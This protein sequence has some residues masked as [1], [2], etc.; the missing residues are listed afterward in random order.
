MELTDLAPDPI[1]QF[2]I[3]YDEIATAGLAEPT[4]MALTTTPAEAHSQPISRHVLL[5][6]VDDR[7]FAWV[8]NHNSRKGRHLAENPRACLLFPWYPLHKQV[9]VTGTVSLAPDEESD[10]YFATRPRESQIASWA[11]DQSSTIP[12]ERSWLVARWHEFAERFEGQDVP[13][14]PHWGIYRLMPLTIELWSQAPH[15]MHDR[16]I[17]QR[18]SP[19]EP[20]TAQR[21]AP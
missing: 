18:S 5:R 12:P 7:G 6:E 19:E 13:R 11:S 14:P 17:Y 15:R 8:S 3:W 1:V 4:T 2:Q 21:L 10:A 16:F 9:I 20:W